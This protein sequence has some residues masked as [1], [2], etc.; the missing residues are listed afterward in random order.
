[1]SRTATL[2][3]P[4]DPLSVEAIHT[5]VTSKGAPADSGEVSH[6]D[7]DAGDRTITSTSAE[8]RETVTTLDAKG[9]V[10]GVDPDTDAS[11]PL[12]AIAIAYDAKPGGRAR[13]LRL[14]RP[15]PPG[16]PHRRRGR[17]GDLGL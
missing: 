7:Y 11:S 9:R 14:R 13:H 17:G 3:D 10:T 8:G 16:Q 4:A 12:A 5:T 15:Q 1:M 2:S 6:I